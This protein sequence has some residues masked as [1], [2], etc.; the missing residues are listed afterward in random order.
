MKVVVINGIEYVPREKPKA[1]KNE[2]ENY[3]EKLILKS[4]IFKSHNE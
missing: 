3:Y 2:L 1:P 4:N